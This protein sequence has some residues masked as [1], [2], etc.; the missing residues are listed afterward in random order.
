MCNM[1]SRV[2]KIVAILSLLVCIAAAGIWIR[3][4]FVQDEISV[5][6][7]AP[8]PP[9]GR[10]TWVGVMSLWG[11]LVLT[12]LVHQPDDARE[13]GWTV[14]GVRGS[15]GPRPVWRTQA[16]TPP[17]VY[18]PQHIW[19]R[20]GFRIDESSVIVTSSIVFFERAYDS[21]T[22]TVPLWAVSLVSGLPPLLWGI[23][24]GRKRN[25]RAAGRC[26]RCGYDLRASPNRC[27][28]CGK[29]VE[30]SQ[31]PIP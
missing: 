5:R 22:V 24:Y 20:M 18:Q 13:S 27:P 19:E 12:R 31:I 23:L 30:S 15:D 26:S 3:S 7:R 2:G 10:A 16:A 6:V 11:K 4:Y 21:L 14:S 29:P 9:N 25:W 17:Y 8:A 1:L 28:E